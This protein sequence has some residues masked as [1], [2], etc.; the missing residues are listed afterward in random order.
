MTKQLDSIEYGEMVA[1][2]NQTW[3]SIAY[4]I[5][6]ANGG[7]NMKRDEVIEVVLDANYLEMYGGATAEQYKAFRALS[8]EKQKQVARDAF[9]SNLY[10]Y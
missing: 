1:A 10:G 7:E 4:D 8:Y 6:E 2:L 3:Q 9:K 5:L